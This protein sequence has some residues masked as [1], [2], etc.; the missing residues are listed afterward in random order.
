MI[1]LC[2]ISL[3]F[4]TRILLMPSSFVPS[5]TRGVFQEQIFVDPG[6]KEDL[7]E[8]FD[9]EGKK[10]LERGGTGGQSLSG[11][12]THAVNNFEVR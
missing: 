10:G 7:P 6:E 9:G 11:T 8:V 4:A 5:T 3:T 2:S 12:R 1:V